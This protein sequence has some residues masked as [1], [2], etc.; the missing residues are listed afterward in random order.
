MLYAIHYIT[1]AF[2]CQ[3]SIRLDVIQDH[4]LDLRQ[5]GKLL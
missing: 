1:Y 2:T 4:A 5:S 3:S